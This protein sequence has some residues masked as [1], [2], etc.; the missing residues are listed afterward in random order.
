[1]WPPRKSLL[2]D[3]NADEPVDNYNH[4]LLA[5][6]NASILPRQ[7]VSAGNRDTINSALPGRPGVEKNNNL[8][9]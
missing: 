6:A 9:D 5:S 8:G 2:F 1:M 3:K 7:T 4:E